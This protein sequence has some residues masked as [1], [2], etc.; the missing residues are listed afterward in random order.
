M[1][2]K[3]RREAAM[4]LFLVT[5][6]TAAILVMLP[7]VGGGVLSVEEAAVPS[8]VTVIHKNLSSPTVE[9]LGQK[10][11]DPSNAGAPDEEPSFDAQRKAQWI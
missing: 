7:V 9:E 6:L 5:V 8:R 2:L 4:R 1:S 11:G 10:A 3:R